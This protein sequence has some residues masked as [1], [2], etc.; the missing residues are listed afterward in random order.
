[1]MYQVGDYIMYKNNGIYTVEAIGKLS[2]SADK[3]KEYYTLRPLHTSGNA[4]IYVPVDT[5]IFMRNV[6]TKQEAQQYLIEL[7]R[8]QPKPFYS[9]KSSLL[10]AHYDGLLA[11]YNIEVQLSLFKELCL[12]EKK[13]RENGKKLGQLET[14]YKTQLEQLLSDEFAYALSEAPDLSRKRLYKASSNIA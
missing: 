11:K 5:N 4:H 6:I 12:K 9:K 2:F 1:M 7:K 10:A 14:N 8:L 3:E 13:I